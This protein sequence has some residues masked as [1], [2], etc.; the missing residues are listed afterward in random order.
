M[1]CQSFYRV[2][3]APLLDGSLP[4]S[5]VVS[6]QLFVEIFLEVLWKI[7]NNVGVPRQKLIVG[8]MPLN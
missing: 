2:L 7:D 3:G 1:C 5:P 8:V 4:N 6:T